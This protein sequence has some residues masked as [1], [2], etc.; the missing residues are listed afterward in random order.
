LTIGAI[1]RDQSTGMPAWG[2]SSRVPEVSKEEGAPISRQVESSQR[3][4]RTALADG[5]C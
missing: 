1:G 3:P 4:A 2:E 5:H